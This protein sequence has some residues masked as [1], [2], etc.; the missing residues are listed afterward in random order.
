MLGTP[1]DNND[2]DKVL[3]TK[4]N[5]AK[6]LNGDDGN[7]MYLISARDT[8]YIDKHRNSKKQSKSNSDSGDSGDSGGSGGGDSGGSGGGSGSGSDG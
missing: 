6:V 1:L 3:Q 2:P 4:K 8:R 7:N 5:V